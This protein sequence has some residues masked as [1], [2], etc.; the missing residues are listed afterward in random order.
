MNETN[1]HTM[2]AVR[3]QAYVAVPYEDVICQRCGRLVGAFVGKV[4]C[5][6]CGMVAIVLT[7][8]RERT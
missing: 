6:A 2:T 3:E 1:A 7:G 4:A 5:Q 8:L